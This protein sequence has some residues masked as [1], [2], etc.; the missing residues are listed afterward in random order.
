[1]KKNNEKEFSNT[2]YRCCKK[3][4]VLDRGFPTMK[5][6][7]NFHKKHRVDEIRYI[8]KLRTGFDGSRET[9]AMRH[10]LTEE[11][12]NDQACK[13]KETR[14]HILTEFKIYE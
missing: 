11:E 9:L 1:M 7:S 8:F 3:R 2:N 10:L 6:S 12:T 14:V 13:K 4:T 5:Y